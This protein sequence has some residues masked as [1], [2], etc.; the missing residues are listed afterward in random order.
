MDTSGL[1][2]KYVWL[3]RYGDESDVELDRYLGKGDKMKKTGD[4]VTVDKF[5]WGEPIGLNMREV[6]E[7]VAKEVYDDVSHN[8]G[9]F[10]D[11]LS[12]QVDRIPQEYLK[13]AEIEFE[14]YEEYENAYGTRITIF[15]YR[16]ET[17]DE[18]AKRK[19]EA[20]DRES[21]ERRLY[22]RLKAKYEGK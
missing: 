19:K 3:Y 6:R 11:W 18:M 7:I 17:D 5:S 4:V 21:D 1:E 15:Y 12:R 2:P 10:V 20:I 9:E 13:K 16:P 14:N 22:E 8:L